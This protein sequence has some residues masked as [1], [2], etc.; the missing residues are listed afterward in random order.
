MGNGP[1]ALKVNLDQG[2]G[3]LLD[4]DVFKAVVATVF[5][6]DDSL[7][8]ISRVD[9]ELDALLIV[10]ETD[11]TDGNRILESQL[12]NTTFPVVVGIARVFILPA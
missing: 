5:C 3:L 4:H 10:Q 2:D 1:A 12:E 8:S 6:L 9:M 7:A 11:A